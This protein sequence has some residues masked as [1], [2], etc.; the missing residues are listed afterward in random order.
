[1]SDFWL[2]FA[3]EGGSFLGVV[4]V[5]DCDDIV[6]GARRAHEAGVNPGGQVFGGDF[7]PDGQPPEMAALPRMRLLSRSDLVASGL[8]L[9]HPDGR[10]MES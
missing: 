8:A 6:D 7:D 4:I 9:A 1:M 2:S 5:P 10:D 3:Q